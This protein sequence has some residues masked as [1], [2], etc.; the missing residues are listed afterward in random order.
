MGSGSAGTGVAF[1]PFVVVNLRMD[2]VLTCQFVSVTLV[3]CLPLP[4]TFTYV[5]LTSV[6]S[7]YT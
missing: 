5:L 6:P 2:C 7:T 3:L 1:P 4:A